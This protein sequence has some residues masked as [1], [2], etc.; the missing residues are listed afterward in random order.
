[1]LRRNTVL[2]I[3]RTTR[4]LVQLVLNSQELR[5]RNF[6]TREAKKTYLVKDELNGLIFITVVESTGPIVHH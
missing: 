1:M 3:L 6:I 2:S 5:Q 4:L